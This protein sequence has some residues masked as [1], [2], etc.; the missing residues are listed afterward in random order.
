MEGGLPNLVASGLGR[1]FFEVPGH[2]RWSRLSEGEPPAS[3]WLTRRGRPGSFA[4]AFSW[5]RLGVGGPRL[6]T[7]VP[8][9]HFGV[10]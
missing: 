6:L 9:L 7:E 1:V 3:W 5:W 2:D 10:H 4:V 8:S